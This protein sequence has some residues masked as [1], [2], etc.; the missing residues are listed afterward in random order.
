M[1]IKFM[2][3]SI[4]VDHLLQTLINHRRRPVDGLIT[5]IAFATVQLLNNPQLQ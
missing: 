1:K 5:F 4:D 3:A 2:G